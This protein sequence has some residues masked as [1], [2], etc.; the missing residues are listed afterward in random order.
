MGQRHKRQLTK[1]RAKEKM[2]QIL[3]YQGEM[4]IKTMR[5]HYTH[6]NGPNPEHQML[7]WVE[8]RNPL[9]VGNAMVQLP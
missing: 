2:I 4:Q 7:M 1:R 8:N 3:C 9:L 6:Q 5:Y